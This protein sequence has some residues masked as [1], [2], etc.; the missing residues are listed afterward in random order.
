MRRRCPSDRARDLQDILGDRDRINGLRRGTMSPR[1]GEPVDALQQ[2]VV[3]LI[4]VIQ[5]VVRGACARCGVRVSHSNDLAQEV[6]VRVWSAIARRA[7]GIQDA[8]RLA[9]WVGSVSR[10]AVVDF[11]R[12]AQRRLVHEE[13]VSATD[14]LD[15]PRGRSSAVLQRVWNRLAV[16][17]D[18]PRRIAM[19]SEA[20]C[21]LSQAIASLPQMQRD[22]L[23][24]SVIEGETLAVIAE[25]HGISATAAHR[26]LQEAIDYVRGL[27]RWSDLAP[28]STEEIP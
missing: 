26:E 5:R 4:R 28:E 19:S 22:A 24:R 17:C 25:R 20:A 13:S 6:L 11:A 14:V 10:F 18:E 21:L 16:T 12:Q 7:T 15:G 9:R 27:L 23:L 3:D 1:S 8:V 2:S